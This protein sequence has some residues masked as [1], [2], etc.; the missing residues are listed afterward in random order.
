MRDFIERFIELIFSLIALIIAQ[1]ITNCFFEGAF[2]VLLFGFFV[3]VLLELP[4]ENV[5]KKKLKNFINEK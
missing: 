3:I 2:C 5:V 4:I 1:V